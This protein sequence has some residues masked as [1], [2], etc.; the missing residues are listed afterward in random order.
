MLQ[1]KH[2]YLGVSKEARCLTCKVLLL[3]P[4]EQS[5]LD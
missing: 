1:K 4:S 2:I 3:V 5:D